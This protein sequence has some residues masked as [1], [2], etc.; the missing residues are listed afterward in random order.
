MKIKMTLI[1]LTIKI[2]IKRTFTLEYI[3]VLKIIKYLI[4]RWWETFLRSR[5]TQIM[6]AISLIMALYWSLKCKLFVLIV[7]IGNHMNR[8]VKF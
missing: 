5:Y 6:K 3:V 2:K 8:I 4:H 1:K 7:I